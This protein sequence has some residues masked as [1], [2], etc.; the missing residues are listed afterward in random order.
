MKKIIIAALA[1]LPVGCTGFCNAMLATNVDS[2][3]DGP[4]QHAAWQTAL[5]LLV[6]IVLMVLIGAYAMGADS[7]K[8]AG[9]RTFRV[10]SVLL[11]LLPVV[12]VAQCTASPDV[13]DPIFPKQAIVVFTLM[14]IAPLL[15]VSY[16]LTLYFK[17]G[18]Q[19]EPDQGASRALIWLGAAILGSILVAAAFYT[20]RDPN[21]VQF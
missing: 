8:L 5:L 2:G 6:P 18:E 1:S 7:P 11:L 15:L 4:A 10:M 9:A 20:Y 16:A 14:A 3:Y 17:R 13:S 19:Q 21:V 12:A